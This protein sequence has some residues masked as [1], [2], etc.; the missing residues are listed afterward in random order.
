[1][2]RKITYENIADSIEKI[3][4]F[5]IPVLLQNYLQKNACINKE[6]HLHSGILC[7]NSTDVNSSLRLDSAPSQWNLNP[8]FF[9]LR[10]L[11]LLKRNSM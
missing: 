4:A 3:P 6:H 7:C 11:R 8:F 1:M 10:R 9:L 2:Q 5:L